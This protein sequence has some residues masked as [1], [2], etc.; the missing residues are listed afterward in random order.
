MIDNNLHKMVGQ[1]FMVGIP[2]EEIDD[3]TIKL[4]KQ[5]HIGNFVLYERRN[6]KSL[7]K[8]LQLIYNLKKLC[9]E[10]NG[11]QPFIAIDNEGGVTSQLFRLGIVYPGNMAI[12]SLDLSMKEKKQIMYQQAKYIAED[13]KSVGFNMNLAPVVEIASDP[14]NPSIGSRS[15]GTTPEVVS[16]LSSVYVK[17][18]KENKV[19]T[20][21]K[22]YPGASSVKVDTHDDII[23]YDVSLEQL[24][25]WE[26]KPFKKLI[27]SGVDAVMTL[28]IHFPCFDNN[29][30]IPASLSKNAIRYLREKLK[31]NGLVISDDLEMTAV[32]KHFDIYKSSQMAVDAGVDI[33]LVCHTPQ[34]MMNAVE[35]VYTKAKQGVIDGNKIK[36]AYNRI[37]SAKKRLGLTKKDVKQPDYEK[38]HKVLWKQEKVN[39]AQKYMSMAITVVKDEQKV[40]PLKLKNRQKILVIDPFHVKFGINSVV[41]LSRF[42]RQYHPYTDGIL[43]DP[44]EESFVSRIKDI[45]E[46]SKHFDY[47]IIGTDDAQFW[48]SQ[49]EL[50]KALVSTGKPHIVVAT[51]N[52]FDI[53]KLPFVKT[54]IVTYTIYD[55]ALDAAAKVIF[56]ITTPKSKFCLNC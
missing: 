44:K 49:I 5:Y 1:M 50:V 34:K 23:S 24:E 13:V 33:M 51:R 2:G 35:N 40:I 14:E 53:I 56:G 16:T 54:Y 39:F 42:I 19:A 55:I 7:Q 28:H 22:H 17:A 26:L 32:E 8:T 47:L 3:V 29:N 10:Y 6:V 11:V 12:S 46:Y 38:V 4:I 21:G 37:L 18:H 27:L 52:P 43:F 41:E 30:I 45:V 15:F 20:V 31:F 9:V 48:P 25:S 36:L